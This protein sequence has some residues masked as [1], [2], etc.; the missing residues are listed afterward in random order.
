LEVVE[1]LKEFFVSLQQNCETKKTHSN[2]RQR[3]RK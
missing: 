1:V 3:K 2:L